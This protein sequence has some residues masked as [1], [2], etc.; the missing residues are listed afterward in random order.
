MILFV[1]LII[2]S[3]IL[4]SFTIDIRVNQVK[5]VMFYNVQTKNVTFVGKKWRI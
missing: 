1:S 5:I 3:Y 4:L 2:R